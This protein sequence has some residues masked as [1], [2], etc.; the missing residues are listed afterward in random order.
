MALV[1]KLDPERAAA[2]QQGFV[3]LY[4]TYREGD[5]VHA[6]RRYLLTVGT[7]R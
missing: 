7:R 3:D 5:R 2:F 1:A 6:P 4:E